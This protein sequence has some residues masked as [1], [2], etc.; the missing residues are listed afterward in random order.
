M[1]I[2]QASKPDMLQIMVW[3]DSD[4]DQVLPHRHDI[5]ELAVHPDTGRAR[6]IALTDVGQPA[7]QPIRIMFSSAHD[8][9]SILR[10][11]NSRERQA[12]LAT[13]IAVAGF[14]SLTG[15]VAARAGSTP[16]SPQS[17]PDDLAL[18]ENFIKR[19]SPSS[20][21]VT[22]A[23]PDH[24]RIPD[25]IADIAIGR[26]LLSEQAGL[27]RPMT[28]F[29][30]HAG[31]GVSA[32][33]AAASLT[34]R[35]SGLGY[36]FPGGFAEL[37]LK[38]SATALQSVGCPSAAAVAFYGDRNPQY[39]QNR[40]Q[41]ARAWPA[42]A[43]FMAQS[44]E[45]RQAIDN[46]MPLQPIIGSLTG[47]SKGQ[48]KRL[49]RLR[50]PLPSGR[51]FEF[52]EEVRGHDPMGV[53][54]LRRY[55]LGSEI[56][57]NQFLELVGNMDT[58]LVPANETSW[59]RFL[60][61]VSACILPLSQRFLSPAGPL[62]S[63][64]RGDWPRYHEQMA[65]AYG[66]DTLQFD[67]RQ[68]SMATS[69]VMEAIDDFSLSVFL[70]CCLGLI[71]R[72]GE[73]LPTPSP[74]DLEQAKRLSHAL[75]IGN[76][77][78]AAVT[79]VECARRWMT[80]IPA[81]IEAEGR[82]TGDN[83]AADCREAGS[84]PKLAGDYPTRNGLVV[85]CLASEADLLEESNRLSHCVGRLYLR[86]ARAGKCHIFSIRDASRAVSHS[87]FEVAAPG[88]GDI[89]AFRAGISIVQHKALRNRLP[90]AP[91]VEAL[92]DWVKSVSS[93]DMSIFLKEV[94]EWRRG[95]ALSGHAGPTNA[96][97]TQLSPEFAWSA[98]L[99]RN[100]HREEVRQSV[101]N[102]WSTH[103]LKGAPART[104][105]P[106]LLFAQE[107]YR[108]FLTELSPKAALHSDLQPRS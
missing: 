108:R 38:A 17:G 86:K 81:L 30:L 13:A 54:R 98:V 106:V 91:A 32:L 25:E 24:V 93:G 69:D 74:N 41:A 28:V 40:Q 64:S 51:V 87:T 70:P 9:Q 46:S 83:A 80:R 57:T 59:A 12:E 23:I 75:I 39:C 22:P 65:S 76:S 79:L 99:G 62:L 104:S 36:P 67:R 19:R 2:H 89:E 92:A 14:L 44:A 27:L 63:A 56:T 107:P 47:L 35:M 100:W 95:A 20:A 97:M 31:Q 5:L 37:D 73:T 4:S 7:L 43:E 52:G 45:C 61:L 90:N 96:G 88:S 48:L 49:A 1:I 55:S 72:A 82:A 105:D 60:D 16:L 78:N 18:F 8:M 50:D 26:T 21:P 15:L 58:N 53:D 103:V 3:I 42:L 68:I 29:G 11:Q 102:E 10:G 77:R 71:T 34:R 33:A 6:C 85:Q 94:V 66:T 84:W 101:W